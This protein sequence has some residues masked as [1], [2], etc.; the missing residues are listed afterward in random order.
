MKKYLLL[1]TAAIGLLISCQKSTTEVWIV[2]SEMGDCTGVVPQK[3]LVVKREGNPNWEYWYSGIEGFD[4]EPG[5]EYQIRV[6]KVEVPNPPADGSS[7]Q[8]KLVKVMFAVEKDSE[9]LPSRE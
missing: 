5:H 8:Y 3:C 7:V 4:Y 6:K 2:A 9:H 1:L